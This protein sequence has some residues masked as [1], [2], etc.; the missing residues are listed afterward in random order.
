MPD[1]RNLVQKGIYC[2]PSPVL[3]GLYD[4]PVQVSP[5]SISLRSHVLATMLSKQRCPNNVVGTA[6]SELRCRNN[7]SILCSRCPVL[8]YHGTSVVIVLPFAQACN[9]QWC[10][11]SS[12]RLPC[13]C[14]QINTWL[15]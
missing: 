11:I 3:E 1:G 4:L 6:L 5:P 7:F 2:Q 12:A 8:I 9:L 10:N 15:T 13:S 14:N